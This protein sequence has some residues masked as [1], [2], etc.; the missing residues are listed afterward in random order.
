M[1]E[2]QRP[3]PSPLAFLAGA[4]KKAATK[5]E[6]NKKVRNWYVDRYNGVLMQRNFMAVIT[7]VCLA[8]VIVSVIVVAEITSQKTIEPFVIQVEEKSGMTQ[9]VRPIAR[10]Y[11]SEDK[12]LNNYFIVRY[13][14]SREEYFAPTH[15]YDYNT[16][17]RLLSSED[18]YRNF[19]YLVSPNNES[20]P[21]RWGEGG[22]RDVKII[23]VLEMETPE[24]LKGF[25]VQVR[26][27]VTDR[28]NQG[29][30][31]VRTTQYT[32]VARL[33]YDYVKME[34]TDEELYVNPV[35]FQVM[36]Y[37]TTEEYAEDKK[38]K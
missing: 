22:S 23:S 33:R 6:R 30:S 35:G 32:K 8:A 38:K 4:R 13:V 14:R 31:N 9:I 17:T 28:V 25:T 10:T 19:R 18:V 1:S 2:A 20:S 27:M 11:I 7:V 12:A 26:F 34:L 36:Q 21:V 37:K 5:D 15:E 24:G 29:G 3:K 16:V